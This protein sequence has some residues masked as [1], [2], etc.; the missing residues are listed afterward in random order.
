MSFFVGLDHRV[1]RLACHEIERIYGFHMD[2]GAYGMDVAMVYDKLALYVWAVRKS[3]RQ[4]VD[5][6][7]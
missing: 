7:N 6:E 3:C 1:C 4:R 2:M 5:T